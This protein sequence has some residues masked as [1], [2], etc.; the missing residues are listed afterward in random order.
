MN[1]ARKAKFVKNKLIFMEEE[2]H[3]GI[4]LEIREYTDADYFPEECPF[5]G[6]QDIRQ[7]T[8]KMREIL[9]SLPI[10]ISLNRF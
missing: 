8:Y 7:H 5:C 6:G 2:S 3:D 10:I 1:I 4:E 9:S